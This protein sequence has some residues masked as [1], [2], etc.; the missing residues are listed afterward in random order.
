MVAGVQRAHQPRQPPR[1]AAE[2]LELANLP[3]RGRD[4][5]GGCLWLVVGDRVV[6]C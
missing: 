4:G 1:A 5:V 3:G 6:N 2:R